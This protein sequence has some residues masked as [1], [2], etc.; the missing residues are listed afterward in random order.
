MTSPSPLTTDDPSTA[1]ASPSAS[2]ASATTVSASAVVT[3]KKRGRKPAKFWVSL[4]TVDEPYK[5]RAA[6]CRHC[7]VTVKYHKKWEQAKGHLLKCVPFLQEMRSLAPSDRPDW[8]RVEVEKRRRAS[9]SRF[10]FDVPH[11]LPLPA[12]GL[13]TAASL[14]VADGD[15][16]SSWKSE[17][18]GLLV[19][20][21]ATSTLS[22]TDRQ[23]TTLMKRMQSL[24]SSS[25][26][27]LPG[28]FPDAAEEEGGDVLAATLERLVDHVRAAVDQFLSRQ[29]RPCALLVTAYQTQLAFWLASGDQLFLWKLCDRMDD[30]S[31][32]TSEIHA[33]A[34]A[35][36]AVIA[37]CVLDLER[38][39]ASEVLKQLAAAETSGL[40]FVR[41]APCRVV[42]AMV[43]DVL[44]SPQGRDLA[45]TALQCY[46]VLSLTTLSWR[47]SWAPNSK[48]S[49]FSGLR[50]LAVWDALDAVVG[51]SQILCDDE[52]RRE[53]ILSSIQARFPLGDTLTEVEALLA[54]PSFK[55]R[56]AQCRAVLEPLREFADRIHRHDV[57]EIVPAL[58][59]LR[60]RLKALPLE[61]EALSAA[62]LHSLAT[63]EAELLTPEAKVAHLV[64]PVHAGALL[65]AS[66]NLTAEHLLLSSH[67]LSG[68]SKEEL[69]MQLTAFQIAVNALQTAAG[70]ANTSDG[71]DT[72]AET[73]A[74]SFKMLETRKKSVT[75]YWLTDGRQW[76]QLQRLALTVLR[77]PKEASL[78]LPVPGHQ[79]RDLRHVEAEASRL[80]HLSL[81]VSFLRVNVGALGVDSIVQGFSAG[82]RIPEVALI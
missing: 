19:A 27:S 36:P 13:A 57:A 63:H 14:S 28:S 75:Q 69:Y 23:I 60:K 78:P 4:T 20:F 24:R 72:V 32:I 76:P 10:P 73:R 16:T 50:P 39:D 61:S 29:D 1:A 45:S 2:V 70:T 51:L 74:F 15:E 38:E 37:T 67:A 8:F 80:G 49:V 77:A 9:A 64:D 12:A 6:P 55:E 66:D 11:E 56:L 52:S 33:I 65:E 81:S 17:L 42:E 18:L 54:N 43:A 46:D 71:I 21:G 40:R 7:G 59:T 30:S 79:H 58:V 34:A 5:Q 62:V 35:V 48:V 25:P 3:G 53:E 44:R 41:L 26:S 22:P 68:D 47:S 31:A 82:E